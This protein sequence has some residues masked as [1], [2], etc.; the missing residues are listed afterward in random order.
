M[1]VRHGFTYTPTVE[2]MSN[3]EIAIRVVNL[4][5]ANQPRSSFPASPAF[6]A[7]KGYRCHVRAVA[8]KSCRESQCASS[9]KSRLPPLALIRE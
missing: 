2:R 8:S 7:P 3:A 5:R 9:V 4:D 1:L 6:D